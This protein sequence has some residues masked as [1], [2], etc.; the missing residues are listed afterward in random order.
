[1]REILSVLLVLIIVICH[2]LTSLLLDIN[3]NTIFLIY[4]IWLNIYF[5]VFKEN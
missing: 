1:M 4:L 5:V 3:V 2:Y